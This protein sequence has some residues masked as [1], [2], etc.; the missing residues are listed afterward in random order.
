MR[1]VITGGKGQLGQALT[2]TLGTH[3]LIINDLP[4]FDITSRLAIQQAIIDAKPDLVIHC[5]AYTDVDGCARQPEL[6]YQVNASGTQNVA[7]A[8]QEAGAEM[9]HLSTNEVFAGDQPAGYEE[10]MPLNPQN[11]YGRSKAAAEH[12]VQAIL[13]RFYIVRTAWLYAPGGKNFIHAI[14][15][16]ARQTGEIRVVTDEISNPTYVKDLA[17]AI[18]ELINTHQYGI[19]HLVNSGSCSR[20]AF[21]NEILSLADLNQVRN[22]PILL[23]D[24]KRPSTPPRFGALLNRAGSAL[25]ISLRPWQ[26]ALADYMAENGISARAQE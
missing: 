11:S 3:Q 17:Q 6:A 12:M 23:R 5:A 24:Y 16:H 13:R 18:S 10:W 22:T 7:L 9:V 25:G 14:L 15:Q 20:W 4:E 26:D 21:A 8:C 19:Y 1:I 2:K